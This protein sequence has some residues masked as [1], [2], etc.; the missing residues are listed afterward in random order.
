VWSAATSTDGAAILTRD[1]GA[2]WSPIASGL[3]AYLGDVAWLDATTAIVVGERGTV[4]T[5]RAP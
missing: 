4:L 1:G 5:Y 2:T 3:D